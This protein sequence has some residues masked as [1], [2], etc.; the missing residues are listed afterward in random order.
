MDIDNKVYLIQSVIK[1]NSCTNVNY[2]YL[3]LKK[4]ELFYGSNK[5]YNP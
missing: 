5:N 2:L 4:R 3:P 1:I